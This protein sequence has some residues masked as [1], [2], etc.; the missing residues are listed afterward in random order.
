M[1]IILSERPKS[2]LFDLHAHVRQELEH[3]ACS[4][5]QKHPASGRAISVSPFPRKWTCQWIL[6]LFFFSLKNVTQHKRKATSAW[7]T[8]PEL[9]PPPWVTDHPASLCSETAGPKLLQFLFQRAFCFIISQTCY[10]VSRSKQPPSVLR[11]DISIWKPFPLIGLSFFLAFWRSVINNSVIR[12]ERTC[13]AQLFT[14]AR[15]K[16]PVFH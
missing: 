6:S 4:Q 12:T 5:S 7:V 11:K 14:Y 15:V 13:K 1:E 2:L 9:V 10:F 16:G 8:V 3:S